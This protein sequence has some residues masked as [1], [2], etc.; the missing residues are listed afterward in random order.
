MA[1]KACPIQRGPITRLLKKQ[2]FLNWVIFLLVLGLAASFI[3]IPVQ[4]IIQ[5]RKIA[6]LNN[7]CIAVL[8][9]KQARI[10]ELEVLLEDV[11]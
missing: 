7:R 11:E 2:R 8:E 6:D 4:K 5:K 3:L 9:H 1:F 10:S